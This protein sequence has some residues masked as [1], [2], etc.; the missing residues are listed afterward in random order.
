MNTR[1]RG[2]AYLSLLFV[3]MVASFQARAEYKYTLVN[4][5]GAVFTQLWGINNAGLVVG[6][7]SFDPDAAILFDFTYDPGKGVFT[8]I[9]DV[10]GSASTGAIGLNENGT[11]VGST[12]PDGVASSAFI[13]D[14]KGEHTV[15]NQPG[16]DYTT[17]RAIGSSGKVTGYSTTADFSEFT[18]FIYDPKDGSFTEIDFANSTTLI[19]QGISGRGDVVGSVTFRANGAF[20]GSPPGTYAFLR[21]KSGSVAIFRIN[22]ALTR[23]RGISDA[24]T[25]TGHA[26]DTSTGAVVGFVGKLNLVPG[27]P[28][29][30]FLTAPPVELLAVP[31]MFSTTPQGINNAGTIVGSADDGSGMS[32]GFIATPLPSAKK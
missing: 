12:S 3:G 19:P 1:L 10:P 16:W 5:P 21:D 32:S 24:G 9:P 2:I 11:L 20:P 4:Y 8:A 22:A 29:V 25:I 27:L 23:A 30:Q 26:V 17:A 15:F 7:A 6:Q 14:K 28:G 18:G 13:L 31:G